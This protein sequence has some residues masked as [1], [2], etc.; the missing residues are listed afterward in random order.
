[1]LVFWRARAISRVLSGALAVAIAALVGLGPGFMVL[2][3]TLPQAVM[4]AAFLSVLQFMRFTVAQSAA[5]REVRRRLDR[6]PPS[7]R[8][9]TCTLGEFALGSFLNVG[10]HGLMASSLPPATPMPERRRAALAS[11]LGVALVTCWSPFFVALAFVTHQMPGV[12]VSH[13]MALG[14]VLGVLGLMGVLA[15]H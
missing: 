13:V 7:Q 5:L 3:Q 11:L 9:S 14:L 1:P 8:L 2:W 6:L 4:F 12:P 10:A 15:V